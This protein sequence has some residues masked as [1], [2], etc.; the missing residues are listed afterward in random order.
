M[1]LEG[2]ITVRLAVRLAVR[3]TGRFTVGPT[4][5]HTDIQIDSTIARSVSGL[6]MPGR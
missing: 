5:R 1:R 6:R 2:R 4:G 3:L